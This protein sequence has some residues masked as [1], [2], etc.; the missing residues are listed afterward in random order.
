MA[1][2]LQKLFESAQAHG[3]NSEPDH[4]V[5]DLQ[6]A[7]EIA[8]ELMTPEQRRELLRRYFKEVHCP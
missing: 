7:L 2:N 4:E 5:G 1:A 6:N 8:W 3:E